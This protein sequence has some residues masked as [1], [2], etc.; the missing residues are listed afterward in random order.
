MIKTRLTAPGFGPLRFSP[1][2]WLELSIVPKGEK[3]GL[4]S[5]GAINSFLYSSQGNGSMLILPSDQLPPDITS[6]F[7]NASRS[8]AEYL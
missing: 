8:A 1:T 2:R 6:V 4:H 5:L 3:A 7:E